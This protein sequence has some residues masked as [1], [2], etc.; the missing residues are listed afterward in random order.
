MAGD[1][2]LVPRLEGVS[3]EQFMQQLYPQVRASPRGRPGDTRRCRAGGSELVYF[4]AGL[5]AGG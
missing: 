3:Q 5:W 2:L 4:D 1:R